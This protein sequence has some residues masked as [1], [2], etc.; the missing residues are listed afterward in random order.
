M[1]ILKYSVFYLSFIS[2]MHAYGDVIPESI[3]EEFDA[4]LADQLTPGKLTYRNG[5]ERLEQLT[6]KYDVVGYG[7]DGRIVDTVDEIPKVALPVNG[8]W[9]LGSDR[10]EWGG[11]L[12][13]KSSKGEEKKLI[14][15]NIEDIYVYSYGYIVTAGL[16]HLGM[17]SGSIY[18]VEKDSLNVKKI[19]ALVGAPETSWLLKNGDLLINTWGIESTVFH[20]NGELSRI[21]CTN[22]SNENG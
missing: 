18:L 1:S 3:C 21:S 11:T 13:F 19:H 14:D 7:V 10:G 22:L 2:C 15:D 9:L 20:K 16:A 5:R 17:N 6:F 8:G 4:H 12:V